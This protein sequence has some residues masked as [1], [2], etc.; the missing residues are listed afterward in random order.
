MKLR[1][2]L[3]LAGLVVTPCI[4][5]ADQV[6]TFEGYPG[7]TVFTTQYPGVNFNG[8][9]VLSLADGT[10]NPAFPPHSGENVVYNPTGPMTINFASPVQYFEGYFTY[11]AGLTIDAYNSSNTL[12]G[13]YNSLCTA[14]YQG[15]GTACSPNELGEVTGSNISY[16]VITGGGGN[17]FTLDDA[18]FT[19]SVDTVAA[20]EP[21]SFVLLGSGLLGLAGAARRKLASR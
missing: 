7:Y 9:T 5:H 15:A 6:I 2:L 3:M 20:P 8:A 16:V 4:G 11:N 14:N 17:N 1:N 10:L 19:G 13:V 21:G 12:L 18:E